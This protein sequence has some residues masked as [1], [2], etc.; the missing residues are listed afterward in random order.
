MELFEARKDYKKICYGYYHKNRVQNHKEEKLKFLSEIS[1]NLGMQNSTAGLFLV[2][3]AGG[4]L[5]VDKNNR[6]S[7][8]TNN[9]MIANY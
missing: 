4:V 9:N 3:E 7:M 8:V 1:K 2:K 6:Y 5:H